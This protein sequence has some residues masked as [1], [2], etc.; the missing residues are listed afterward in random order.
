MFSVEVHQMLHRS[1]NNII[2]LKKIR[3]SVI[4]ILWRVSSPSISNY[5]ASKRRI[6][7]RVY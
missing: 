3:Y 1:I 5:I 2:F 7:V 4:N 6:E